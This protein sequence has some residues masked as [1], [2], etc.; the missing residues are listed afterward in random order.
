VAAV[1][2]FLT[3]AGVNTLAPDQHS[4]AA[5]GGAFSQRTVFHLP[6]LPAAREELARSFTELAKRFG[7]DLASTIA[8]ESHSTRCEIDRST[9]SSARGRMGPGI[10][11]MGHP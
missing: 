3:R 5:E 9:V 1:S 6:G 7:M 2:S 11:V 4:T 8:Q 10:G